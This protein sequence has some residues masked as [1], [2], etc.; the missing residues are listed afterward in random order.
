MRFNARAKFVIGV[1]LIVSLMYFLYYKGTSGLVDL[2][3]NNFITPYSNDLGV[4]K[5]NFFYYNEKDANIRGRVD[6]TFNNLKHLLTKV[7]NMS[8]LVK[9]HFISK[10]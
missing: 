6:W 1:L 5:F 4:I 3:W 10:I 7:L 8:K 9:Y 2:F